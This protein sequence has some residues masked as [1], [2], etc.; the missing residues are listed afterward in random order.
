MSGLELIGFFAAFDKPSRSNLI[1]DCFVVLKSL[2]PFLNMHLSSCSMA[3]MMETSV[4]SN[5][6][7]FGHSKFLL[8]SC[9]SNVFCD[10]F[11]VFRLLFGN[12]WASSSTI[13]TVRCRY[14]LPLSTAASTNSGSLSN[15]CVHLTVIATFPVNTALESCLIIANELRAKSEP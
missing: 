8:T 6:Q 11:G 4:L 14:I 9:S 13:I 10:V 12:F 5:F 3:N 15:D 7:V 1:L 2:K